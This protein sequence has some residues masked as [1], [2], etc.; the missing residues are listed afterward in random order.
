M[1]Y[2]KLESAWRVYYNPLD[3]PD[4]YELYW[5]DTNISSL[6]VGT[7]VRYVHFIYNLNNGELLSKSTG[8][9]PIKYETLNEK[10]NGVMTTYTVPYLE[11][12]RK[13]PDADYYGSSWGEP[14]PANP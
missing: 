11:A 3:N 6:A 7:R 14:P 8:M 9:V 1:D 5:T 10:I 13:T 4:Q 12:S 2:S